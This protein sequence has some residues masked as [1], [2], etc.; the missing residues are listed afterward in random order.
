[1]LETILKT[2]AGFLIVALAFELGVMLALEV[3]Y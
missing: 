1:M 3:L 2:V